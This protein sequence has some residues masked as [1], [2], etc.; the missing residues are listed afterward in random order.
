[1]SGMPSQV[2]AA[3]YVDLAGIWP[4]LGTTK[5]PSDIQHL[6]GI[7]TYEAIDGSDITFSV[8]VTVN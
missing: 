8:R 7:G 3:A 1:M 5:V 2:T 4:S 6:T